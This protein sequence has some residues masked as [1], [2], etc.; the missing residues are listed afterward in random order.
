MKAHEFKISGYEI[1][2]TVAKA[3][4]ANDAA[5]SYLPKTWIG[6]KIIIVRLEE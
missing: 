5:Y 4:T 6:K 3:R 1:K 2:E